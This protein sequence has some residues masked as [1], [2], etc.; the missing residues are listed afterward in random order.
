[1]DLKALQIEK[2]HSIE[3]V[4]SLCFIKKRNSESN[5]LGERVISGVHASVEPVVLSFNKMLSI[6]PVERENPWSNR[7]L[8]PEE[9][10]IIRKREIKALQEEIA[11]LKK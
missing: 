7:E 4:N 1:M 3:F 5:H 10:L 9:E 6:P 11:T 8:T 2:I